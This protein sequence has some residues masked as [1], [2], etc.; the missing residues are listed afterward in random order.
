MLIDFSNCPNGYRD[1]GGSDSKRSIEYNDEK[2]IAER[3]ICHW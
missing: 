1:Y 2:Y 3:I